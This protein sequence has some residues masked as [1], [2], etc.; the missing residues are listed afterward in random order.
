MVYDTLGPYELI[1]KRIFNDLLYTKDDMNKYKSMLL[2]TNAHKH[3]HQS[4][5]QLLSNRGYKYKYVITLLMSITS[6]K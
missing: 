6:K 5:G 1:F 4:Q 3:K 2:A